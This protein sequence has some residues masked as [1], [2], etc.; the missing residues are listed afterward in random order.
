MHMTPNMVPDPPDIDG[1]YRKL[2]Y[3]KNMSGGSENANNFLVQAKKIT[4][5]IP[6][7]SR[8]A[9]NNA[10]YNAL[11]DADNIIRRNPLLMAYGPD[12]KYPSLALE[13]LRMH[14]GIDQIGIE[15]DSQGLVQLRL[16]DI[17]VPTDK[18]GNVMVNFRAF[19]E[20][21]DGSGI[22][23]FPT[24]S[25]TDILDGTVD[26]AVFSNKIVFIGTS[27]P[28]LKDLRATP[29]TG[30]MAGVEVHATII[31]NILA[32]DILLKPGWIIAVDALAIAF[33]GTF[34]TLLMHKGRAVLSFVAAILMLVLPMGLG[35]YLFSQH[36]FVFVPI[37][38][39]I[40]VGLTYPILTL[41]RYWQEE[42]Q[43]RQ[44]RDMFGTMVSQDVLHYMEKN[45]GSFS[46]SGH[47]AEATMFFADV[48]GFTTISEMLEPDQLGELLNRYLSP[49][50]QLIQDRSGYVDKYEGDL[51]M[52]E[53]GVP[54]ETEDHAVQA[55]LSALE[56]QAK[57]NE[58][59]PVLK[60][61]FGHDL[62]VR[63]GINTGTVTA[64][65]MGSD[66]RFSYTVMGDAVN[67]ASRLEPANKDYDTDIII[68]EQTFE[69]ASD[70][71]EARLLDKIVVKGKGKPVCIY[72]LVAKKG[73]ISADRRKMLDL[74]EKGVR[75]H[76][77]R[78]W[79][80][81]IASLDEAL[82]LDP[83]DKPSI[84]IRAR[85]LHYMEAPPEADWAGEHVRATKD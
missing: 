19:H 37:W 49:M 60:E 58:L 26:S 23:S 51:I 69:R 40:S 25:A 42:M 13:A 8:A 36:H 32:G 15:F 84:E 74:Y 66:K 5:S 62:Y 83:T 50:T 78:Q 54:F 75:C 55:C 47:R 64:G 56:Q 22:Y 80:E 33:M 27:A 76:W 4:I 73:G 59:R 71:I 6:V 34:L 35:Y 1:N 44:V 17:V 63:M 12:R 10:F 9:G 29:L 11:P 30:E 57:L 14:L 85:I 24:F 61:Q 45:P 18:N 16:Q 46:L 82:K 43:K 53:W 48:Q 7:L 65:N 20:R 2:F 67:L 77:V 3:E 21:T 39:I 52:A 41:I 68:G 79:D 72:E 38:P 31:D 70:E 81:A 28:G